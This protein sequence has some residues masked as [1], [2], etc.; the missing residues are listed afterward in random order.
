VTN[1]SDRRWKREEVE[2]IAE[3]FASTGK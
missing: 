3:N 2:S 1:L